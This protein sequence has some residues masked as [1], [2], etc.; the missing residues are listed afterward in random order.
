[1]DV[2]QVQTHTCDH[3]QKVIFD[4]RPEFERSAK[5]VYD[6]ADQ[7]E[8][9]LFPQAEN[10]QEDQTNMAERG[11]LFNVTFDELCTG[12]AAGCQLFNWMMDAEWISRETIHGLARKD[13]PIDD[14]NDKLAWACR[15]SSLWIERWLGEPCPENTLHK[16]GSSRGDSLGQCRLW[17]STYQCTGNPLDIEFIEFFGLWDPITEKI[18]YRTRDGFQVFAE[19]GNPSSNTVSNRPIASYPGSNK[20]IARI[21][22]WLSDCQEHHNCKTILGAMPMRLIEITGTSEIISLRLRETEEVGRVPFAALSY[23][24]GGEQPLRC[25]SS[26]IVSYRNAIP[27]EKQPPTIQ[28][29]AK[30]C[31]GMGLQYLWI[32]ALC[33]IQDDSNDKSVE[34]AKMN[35]IYGSATVTIV[36]ARSSSATEGFL[37]ERLPGPREGF[38]VSY[39]CFDGELG[40]ITL[41]KLNDGFDPVEP[42]DE[43]AWALQ[44][45]LLSSRIIEFGS[46]QT[47]WICSETRSSGFS[48]K[49]FTDGW[50]RDVNYGGKRLTEALDLDNIR[51]TKST[52]DFYGRP[53]NSQFKEY[54]K[55]MDQWKNICETFTERALTLSSDRALAISGIAQ[56]FAELSG[57]QYIAGLWK[58]CFHFGLLWR[59]EHHL[60]SPKNIPQ[61]T[62][63]QGPSW[64]W[65]SVNEPVKFGEMCRPSEYVAE[66]LSCET[67]LAN[68]KAPYG[69]IREGSG[70][71]VMAAHTATGI[72]TKVPLRS[73]GKFRDEVMILGFGKSFVCY[74][75]V[76]MHCDVKNAEIDKEE[77]K[78]GCVVVE[79]SRRN[80]GDKMAC[81]GLVLRW[82]SP[83]RKTYSRVGRFS[84]YGDS[85]GYLFKEHVKHGQS[86]EVKFDWFADE[87]TV[88]EII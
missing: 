6:L 50:K 42:I 28:D 20:N 4:L 34:I 74:I 19:P 78:A 39:C 81:K 37:G 33:I 40:S 66:I 69:L 79:I 12:A 7:L 57:D 86:A 75:T 27:F 49:G 18:V 2:V 32:D 25:L 51:T 59:I 31:Q 56:I 21:L 72:R 88:I 53:R 77:E 55:A 10:N 67:R 62:I 70:R 61:P 9:G 46:R 87:P 11:E 44:E 52:I 54:V 85:K 13:M 71:L 83:E 3:C 29:A 1:M 41:V 22:S 17:A 82:S 68:E 8:R 14:P 36:A 73:P 63:Y 60:V 47:R 16:I 26:N 5:V 30:V 15:D 48:L 24:W 45:R 64:S 23:C 35:A 80:N 65:L 84:Y 38:I 58:S 43:R 76:E